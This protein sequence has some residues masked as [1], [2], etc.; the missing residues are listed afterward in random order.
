MMMVVR[1]RRRMIN[2][3]D[4]TADAVSDRMA[5]FLRVIQKDANPRRYRC[6]FVFCNIQLYLIGKTLLA[7]IT[8]DLIHS[9][10]FFCEILSQSLV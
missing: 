4:C 1:G 6:K 9:F 5:Q 10:R 7:D 3:W 2:Q 8:L